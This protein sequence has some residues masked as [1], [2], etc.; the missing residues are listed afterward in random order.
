M[1]LTHL[2]IPALTLPLLATAGP[3]VAT[4]NKLTKRDNPMT[5]D[6]FKGNKPVGSAT[7]VDNA[8]VGTVVTHILDCGTITATNVKNF[9]ATCNFM[10]PATSMLNQVLP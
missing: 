3:L 4:P 6:T 1:Q 10:L 2:I 9:P 7:E 8:E 5:V